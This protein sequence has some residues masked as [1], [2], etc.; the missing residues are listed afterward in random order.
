MSTPDR[1]TD[2]AMTPLA[3]ALF[4]VWATLPDDVSDRDAAQALE[5]AALSA[6]AARGV[7]A[8]G[9]TSDS[10]VTDLRRRLADGLCLC[11]SAH[12]DWRGVESLLDRLE[13][14]E[15]ELTITGGL[16][17]EIA[18]RKAASPEGGAK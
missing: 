10:L 17:A 11:S 15:A 2:E 3:A 9:D 6:L 13:R 7:R 1:L 14:V 4:N 12:T 18:D 8:P 16:L 5:Q